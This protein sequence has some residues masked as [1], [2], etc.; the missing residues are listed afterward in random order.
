FMEQYTGLSPEEKAR[1]RRQGLANASYV[2]YADDFVVLSNGT[3]A[4]VLALRE[5]LHQFLSTSLHL[6]LSLEKTKVTHLTDG[7]DFLG[8]QLQR[9]IASK[10]MVTKVSTS[11]KSMRRHLD[12]LQALTS[13]RTHAEAFA[14][15]LTALNRIIEGWCRYYQYAGKATHQFRK[16]T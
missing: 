1:R 15:K 7:F 12:T 9:G 4:Q 6:S 5:E 8:C 11:A 10:G 13:P 2:R 3:H 14:A 16:L